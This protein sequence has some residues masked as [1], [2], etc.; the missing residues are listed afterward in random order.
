[1]KKQV[2]ISK[3][4]TILYK[5]SFFDILLIILIKYFQSSFYVTEQLTDQELK[6]IHVYSIIYKHNVREHYTTAEYC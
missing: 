5:L 2:V 6:T 4:D 1:M 3:K